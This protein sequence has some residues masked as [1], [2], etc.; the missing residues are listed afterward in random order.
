MTQGR[1]PRRQKMAKPQNANS[2]PEGFTKVDSKKNYFKFQNVGDV[3][4]GF[5][6]ETKKQD[7]NLN[8]GQEDSYWFCKEAETGAFVYI[9]EKVSM[10]TM[11]M[12]L[13]PG[14]EFYLTF[15]GEKDS[16]KYKGKKFKEFSLYVTGK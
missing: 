11:K 9:P 5:F 8:K 7:S 15:D 3:F 12:E 4:H 1:R 14:D 16:T 13:A 10:E 2:I 6:I